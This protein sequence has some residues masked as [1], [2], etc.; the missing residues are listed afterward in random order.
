MKYLVVQMQPDLSY[1]FIKPWHLCSQVSSI[2]P[3]D[4]EAAAKAVEMSM[5]F[6]GE[7]KKLKESGECPY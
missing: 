7:V 6:P 5:I 3:S 4:V 1:L 2:Q